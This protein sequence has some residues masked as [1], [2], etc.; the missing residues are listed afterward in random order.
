MRQNHRNTH[1]RRQWKSTLPEHTTLGMALVK[2]IDNQ[3]EELARHRVNRF[4]WIDILKKGGKIRFT[5]AGAKITL[6]EERDKPTHHIK[7]I[8]L[9][10]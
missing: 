8:Y 9:G 10:E 7:R 5:S 2:A 3:R 1:K 6:P 4:D